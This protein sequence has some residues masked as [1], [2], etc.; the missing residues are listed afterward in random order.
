MKTSA[1]LRLLAMLLLMAI[2]SPSVYALDYYWVGGSG[3]WSDHNNHW[4]TTSGGNVF[5]DQVPT[6]MDNVFFDANSFPMGGTV[7]IDPTII[8]CMNMTW[9]GAGNMPTFFCPNDKQVWIYGSLALIPGMVWD[10]QGQVYF[11]AFEMGKTILTAGQVFKNHVYFDGSGGEWTL[12]DE[13]STNQ[14]LQIRSGTL[15]TNDQTVNVLH[16]QIICYNFSTTSV[17]L[18][19]STVNIVGSLY[20][21]NYCNSI[22]FDAAILALKK[23]MI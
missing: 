12:L 4:A 5:H 11:R 6:S 16:F 19:A 22:T 2:Q 7:T 1:A 10:V 20:I 9:T 13:F 8:Y 14:Y 18:G 17:F 23:V 21:Y 3:N 15:R